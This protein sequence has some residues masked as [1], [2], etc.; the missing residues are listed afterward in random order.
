MVKIL[1]FVIIVGLGIGY[2]AIKGQE[3]PTTASDAAENRTKSVESPPRAESTSTAF[4]VP[5]IDREFVEED[6]AYSDEQDVTSDQTPVDVV[7]SMD[8]QDDRTYRA[9]QLD[10]MFRHSPAGLASR[11][12]SYMS[13]QETDTVW[14]G[15]ATELVLT[16]FNS[17][18]TNPQSISVECVSNICYVDLLVSYADYARNYSARAKQWSAD[19]VPG[20]LPTNFHISAGRDFQRVYLFRDTLDPNEL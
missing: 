20:F 7:T 1:A 4:D 15:D 8:P 3:I 14:A 12:E 16:W 2:L 5:G 10:E 19:E 11:I 6:V 17:E 18:G 9:R 13:R